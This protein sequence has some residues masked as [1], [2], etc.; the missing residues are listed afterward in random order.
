M[1]LLPVSDA[2]L[3][4]CQQVAQGYCFAG[5]RAEVDTS[6]DRLGKMIRNAETQKIPVMAVVG[7]KEREAEALNIRTRAGGELGVMAVAEVKTKIV[8]AMASHQPF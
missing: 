4:F 6:G 8:Q 1:R 3:E 7:D 2:Q 5:V